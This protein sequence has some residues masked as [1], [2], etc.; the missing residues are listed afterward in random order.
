MGSEQ[1]GGGYTAAVST[2]AQ[3][4]RQPKAPLLSAERVNMTIAKVRSARGIQYALDALNMIIKQQ[5]CTAEANY[6]LVR[7]G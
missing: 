1:D 5:T 4:G 3:N 7:C 2:L 6:V